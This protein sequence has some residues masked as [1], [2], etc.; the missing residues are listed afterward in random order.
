MDLLE[1]PTHML[2]S[3]LHAALSCERSS[4]FVRNLLEG[5]DAIS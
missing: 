2:R 5:V 4:V 3:Y 1:M